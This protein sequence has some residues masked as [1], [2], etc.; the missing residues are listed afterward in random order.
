MEHPHTLLLDEPTNHLEMTS[1][2]AFSRAI[3]EYE[4]DVVIVLHDFRSSLS[5]LI[6]LLQ[7]LLYNSNSTGLISQVAEELW[8]VKNKKIGN[9]TC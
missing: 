8:E 3:K 2:D 6:L 9:L 4:G 1:I 5:P 7:F